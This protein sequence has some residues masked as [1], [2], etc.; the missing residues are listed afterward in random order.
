MSMMSPYPIN[1]L[2]ALLEAFAQGMGNK[3]QYDAQKMAL[4][5]QRQAAEQQRAQE[6]QR[7]REYDQ[8]TALNALKMAE[9][10]TTPQG[11]QMLQDPAYQEQFRKAG[12]VLP[13]Q[14]QQMQG[15]GVN[16]G[17]PMPLSALSNATVQNTYK[18]PEKPEELLTVGE[19]HTKNGLPMS[20]VAVKYA[21]VPMQ[22]ALQYKLVDLTPPDP[23]AQLAERFKLAGLL[24]D[25]QAQA[26]AKA[27]PLISKA[28][29][30]KGIP[31]TGTATPDGQ[32]L[33]EPAWNVAEPK[34][35]PTYRQ[36]GYS[37]KMVR[38]EYLDQPAHLDAQGNAVVQDYMQPAP[39]PDN[40]KA[41]QDARND[42]DQVSTALISARDRGDV[43]G[44]RMLAGQLKAKAGYYKAQGFDLTPFYPELGKTTE[45]HAQD[46]AKVK[47]EKT[48]A[49]IGADA[50]ERLQ[51]M[52]VEAYDKANRLGVNALN[53]GQ[54]LL[55]NADDNLLQTAIGLAQRDPVVQAMAFQAMGGQAGQE[56]YGK[57]LNSAVEKYLVQLQN[58]SGLNTIPTLQPG[59][60][61]KPQ[62]TLQNAQQPGLLKGTK[63][64][65]AG[66]QD[67]RTPAEKQTR[68][69]AIRQIIGQAKAAIGAK[70]LT[71][72]QALQLFMQESQWYDT[73]E[74]DWVKREINKMK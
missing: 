59:P 19:W 53:P 68:T 17:G 4:D 70:K 42:T 45:Q 26:A 47:T 14:S 22:K 9:Y 51:Q 25:P 5:A 57:A 72:Q 11:W 23:D 31:T 49:K 43:E 40:T 63:T 64:V 10:A 55:I 6:A 35:I 3:Q 27:D 29:I 24:A 18:L 32:V 54:R 36:L 12:G 56:K 15:Q 1:P 2:A 61:G 69:N 41:F 73:A 7:A 8:N 60:T 44:A 67:N 13:I 74:I 21:K 46:A 33:L 30:D 62:P 39:A 16:P 50:G 48:Q 38:D 28:L 52:R 37:P 66:K 34:E 71:K 65:T 20:E 58:G